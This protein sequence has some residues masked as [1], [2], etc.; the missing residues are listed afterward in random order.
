MIRSTLLAALIVAPTGAQAGVAFSEDFSSGA[1]WTLNVSSGTNGADPNFWT[2]SGN[3]GGVAPPGCAGVSNG[4]ATLHVSSVFFPTG[5]AG[6]DAGGL[7]G[8]L[9]CPETNARAKSPSFSTLGLTDLTLEFDFIAN[10]DGLADNASVVYD[11]GSGWQTLVASIKSPL[12]G[13]GQGQWT[14]HSVALPAS[15][16]N[17]AAVRIGFNWSNNDDGVGTN[18]SV[19]IDNI[20]GTNPSVAIDNIVVTSPVPVELLRFE[21]E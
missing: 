4:N 18:P 10:G 16:E 2:I 19:A 11:D 20:V 21:V 7:C 3:E 17:Q 15:M 5:G 8:L 12:C 9:F 1:G 14:H 6:Y 13:G